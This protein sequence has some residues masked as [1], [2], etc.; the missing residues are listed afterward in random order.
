MGAIRGRWN[1]H[2]SIRAREEGWKARSVYKLMEMDNKWRLFRKGQK[3]LD[4]GCY[5]GSWS[6]YALER[7][8]SKGEVIGIDI[9]HPTGIN[10]KNFRFIEAD[11]SRL[12]MDWLREEISPRD[13]VLSDLAP[14]TTGIRW[15]DS[16]F[17]IQL[18]K[19]ALEISKVLLKRDGIFI[20]KIF[21]GEE[22]PG[23]RKEISSYFKKI[24]D[25]RPVAVRSGSYERY[26]IGFSFNR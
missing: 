4:L 12:D 11:V 24:K 3:V 15:R 26:I 17:S 13:I 8:G 6:Q 10:Y 9:R 2:F 18:G 5:P 1:D 22:A 20:C 25:F 19:I 7:V 14:N 21:E 23:F 16:H